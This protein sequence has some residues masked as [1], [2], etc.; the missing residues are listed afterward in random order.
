[1]EFK[2]ILAPTDLSPVAEEGLRAAANL[3]HRLGATLTLLHVIIEEEMEARANAHV[4]RHPVDLIYRDLEA[5]LVEQF[6]R[7]VPPEI[8]RVL[9]AEPMAV[10]GNPGE[11]IVRAARSR[12]ADMIVMATHGRTCLAQVLMGSVAEYVVRAAPC[13]VVTVRPAAMQ[14]RAA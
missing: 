9:F 7:L 1:M 5:E 8:Q 12:A 14:R 10:A 3:A 4:P 13:P 2:R 11:E 6:H